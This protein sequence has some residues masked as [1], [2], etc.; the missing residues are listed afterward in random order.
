MKI[1]E[2]MYTIY[3]PRGQKWYN[4]HATWNFASTPTFFTDKRRA[5]EHVK[6]RRDFEATHRNDPKYAH[7]ADWLEVA[8]IVTVELKE[9]KRESM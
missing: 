3:Y 7:L 5:A 6:Y 8:E 9:T 4:Q 1:G 2:K